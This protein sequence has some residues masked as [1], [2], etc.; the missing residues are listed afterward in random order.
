[1]SGQG[2]NQFA[3]SPMTRIKSELECPVCFNIP[4][5]L[6]VPS[7]PSGHFVC[8]PC[9]KR[10]RDCPTCRQPMPPNNTNSLVGALI[11]QVQHKCKFADKGCE[12]IMMLKDLVTHEK[13]CPERTIPCPEN[14]CSSIV[15]LKDFNDHAV[16]TPAPAT[17]PHSIIKSLTSTFPWFPFFIAKNVLC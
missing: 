4:R 2:G 7:C 10:V 8:R 5:D 1:M 17:G 6:P 11:E 9:K 15:K 16:H 14:T 13:K 3:A 12:V